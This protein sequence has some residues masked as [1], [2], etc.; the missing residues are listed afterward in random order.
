M[1]PPASIL[2]SLLSVDTSYTVLPAT[3][4]SGSFRDGLEQR[5]HSIQLGPGLDGR[6]R[7]RQALA[8]NSVF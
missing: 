8:A 5:Q 1:H 7:Y 2:V 4:T 3:S 6:I